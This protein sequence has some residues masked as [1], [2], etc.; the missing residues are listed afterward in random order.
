MVNEPPCTKSMFIEVKAKEAITSV[1]ITLS[2]FTT[3]VDLKYEYS[4]KN[5]KA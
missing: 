4:N 2:I 3:K 1:T 5:I